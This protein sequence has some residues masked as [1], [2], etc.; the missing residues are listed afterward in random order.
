VERNL[1]RGLVVV[2]SSW[3]GLGSCHDPSTAQP[4]ALEDECEE[5]ASVCFGRDDRFLVVA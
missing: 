3:V 2:S 5:K 1:G 4:D